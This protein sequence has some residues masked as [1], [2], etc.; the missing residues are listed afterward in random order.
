MKTK[1][2]ALLLLT[3]LAV[4]LPSPVLAHTVPIDVTGCPPNH[5]EDPPFS[6]YCID[7]P[8]LPPPAI[9]NNFLLCLIGIEVP[10]LPG[11]F[12]TEQGLVANILTAVLPIILTLAGFI[13]VIV[14]VVSGVQFITSG[15]NPEAAAAAKNRLVFAIIGFIIIILSYAILQ[16]VNRLFLGA[17]LIVV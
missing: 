5:R 14:I 15:G 13:T 8:F 6:G 17:T 11:K 10:G 3:L 4:A 9:C 16:I 7:D 1:I 12:P 2:V